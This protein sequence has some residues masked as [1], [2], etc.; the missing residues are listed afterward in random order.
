MPDQ[1]KDLQYFLDKVVTESYRN[2]DSFE[3]FKESLDM[4]DSYDRISL[5]GIKLEA[6]DRFHAHQLNELKEQ[7]A[8]KDKEI[9]ELKKNVNIGGI[10]RE[11][12][13]KA[14]R[15]CFD[16]IDKALGDSF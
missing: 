10:P 7:L 1:V 15:D 12:L 2:Y 11:S 9:E 5:L 13:S 4:N 14:A 6:K 16:S 8:E 3:D